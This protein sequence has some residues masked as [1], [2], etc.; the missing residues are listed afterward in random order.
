MRRSKD[1]EIKKYDV[2]VRSAHFQGISNRDE[3]IKA[4]RNA[5]SSLRVF[6]E[7]LSFFWCNKRLVLGWLQVSGLRIQGHST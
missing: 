1:L 5:V 4:V 7:L 2:T 6:D 3:N